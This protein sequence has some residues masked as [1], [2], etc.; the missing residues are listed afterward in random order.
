MGIC[1]HRTL[2]NNNIAGIAHPQ[3]LLSDSKVAVPI[4]FAIA[5]NILFSNWHQQL[6]S[7]PQQI[8]GNKKPRRSGVQVTVGQ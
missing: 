8:A 4:H 7:S 2:Q 1:D 5:I 3:N 6:V